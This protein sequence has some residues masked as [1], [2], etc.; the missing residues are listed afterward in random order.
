MK[1]DKVDKEKYMQVVSTR[2]ADI[3]IEPTTECALDNVIHTLSAILVESA[4]EAAPER[5]KFRPRKRLK[6]WSPEIRQAIGDKKE[7]Y[8][9]WKA[10]QKPE[11]MTH[12]LVINRKLTTIHLR[13]LCRIEAA[14][15]REVQRQ[16][17]LDAKASDVKFFHKLINKQRGNLKLCVNELHVGNEVYSSRSDILTGWLEHFKTLATPTDK[18]TFDEEYKRLV[19]TEFGEIMK[20]CSRSSQTLS[21][22]VDQV[23]EAVSSLNRGKAADFYGLTAEHFLHGGEAVLGVVTN[24]VNWLYKFGQLTDSMKIGV[25]T[26]V[27]KKK[28]LSTE[29]KNYRGI[30]I[31]PT[32]TKILEAIL[33]KK[34]GALVEEH[35]NS[36]QRGFTRN[37]SPMN[38]SLIL[39]EVMREYKET[40]RPLYVA[41]LDAKSAFDVVSHP[42]LL[43]K[44]FHLGLEGAEWSLVHSLHSGAESVVK[45]EGSVSQKFSVLQGVRQG[46]IL[47][48]DLYKLYINGLLDRLTMSGDGCFLGEVCCVA[49]AAC[50]DIAVLSP[51][52][53]MLQRLISISVDYSRMERYLLQP[54][55]SVVLACQQHC[56]KRGAEADDISILMGEEPMPVIT[57]AMHMGIMRSE[58][59][60]DTAVTHNI[61]KARRTVY[62]L[63]S[64]GFQGNNGLDPDTSVHILQTYVVPVLVYGLEVVLSRKQLLDKLERFLR[65]ILKSILSLPDTVAEPAVYVLSGLMPVEGIIHKRALTLFGN[66][67]RLSENSV[68]QRIAY[69]QLSIKSFSSNSWFI[70][71][72]KLLVKYGLP[73]AVELLESPPTK[74]RWRCLVREHVDRHWTDEIKHKATLYNSLKFLH[75]ENYR[76]GI[77]HP[78]LHEVLGVRDVT[79]IHVKLKLVT[80]TYI[81]Q[82]NRAIFNQNQVS[83]V[84]MLCHAA[85]ETTHHFLLSCS[86]LE[87]VRQPVLLEIQNIYV[88]YLGETVNTEVLLR[89]ILDGSGILNENGVSSE[90]QQRIER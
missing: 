70:C 32:I 87:S 17:I 30:T 11:D 82:T 79:R 3:C 59:S 67:C 8:R 7:A 71:I 47:S 63:I 86:A 21:I 72:K 6:V 42:S 26:P 48:T 20:M 53:D 84:C 12:Q 41:F 29:A 31:L 68:E 27:F 60:Q 18:A 45:W 39:E 88:K 76:P 34:V 16:E 24:I 36:L 75:C 9:A 78:L 90:V 1:W 44:L 40:R 81:L 14:K 4:K 28:G 35:Q 80:G 49:P 89:L 55:K 5:P 61:E 46:G 56:G 58:D 25:L 13:K 38:C 77:K 52:L 62:S 10:G 51:S 19:E 74:Y 64:A 65:K 85:D 66:I 83:P 2:V 33:R 57:E 54:S 43:R 37:S 23:R 73:G 22:T 50:D 15:A 69:R